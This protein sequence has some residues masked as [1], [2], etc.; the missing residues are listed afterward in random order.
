MGNK[1]D[2]EIK[3]QIE[4]LSLTSGEYEDLCIVMLGYLKPL[5]AIDKMIVWHL[6]STAT[7]KAMLFKGV[8]NYINDLPIDDT[9]ELQQ[10]LN[11][12]KKEN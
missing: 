4:R 10:K 1:L 12:Y 9:L 2:N 5:T 11:I 3:G 8:R 7:N 6:M